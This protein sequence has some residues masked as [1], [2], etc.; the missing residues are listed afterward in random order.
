MKALC[1]LFALIA[2]L[3]S[4]SQSQTASKKSAAM[5]AVKTHSA[6]TL[7]A[8]PMHPEVTSPKPGTCPKCKMDLVKIDVKKPAAAAAGTKSM[9]ASETYACPMHPGVT[10]DAPGTCPKCKMAL[11]KKK[12]VLTYVHF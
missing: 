3:A 12:I 6:K 8:C 9:K 1:V 4:P 5:D 10:S 11:V 2:F 7:Y